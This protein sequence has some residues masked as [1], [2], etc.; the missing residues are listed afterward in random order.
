MNF[1]ISL[2]GRV[3]PLEIFNI[4]VKISVKWPNDLLLNKKLGGMLTEASI[5]CDQVRSIVF[6]FGLNINSTIK[7][8]MTSK[9]YPHL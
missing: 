6:G 5:D 4:Q 8:W 3:F 1:V 9:I 2:S 7:H